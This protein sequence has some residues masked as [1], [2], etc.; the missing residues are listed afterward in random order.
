MASVFGIVVAVCTMFL[1]VF[2]FWYK[3]GD[4]ISEEHVDASTRWISRWA[5][6]CAIETNQTMDDAE[7]SRRMVG[8]IVQ[9]RGLRGLGTRGPAA[10]QSEGAESL[11]GIAIQPQFP[12]HITC[13]L[14][15]YTCNRLQLLT[16]IVYCAGAT[17]HPPIPTIGP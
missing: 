2:R 3:V 1:D 11:V 17:T 13:D 9:C 6:S 14:Y 8:R 5:D 4:L 7:S 10:G 12:L 16:T 15:L